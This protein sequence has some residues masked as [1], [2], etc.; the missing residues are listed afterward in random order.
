MDF[1]RGKGAQAGSGF[2]TTGERQSLRVGRFLMAAGTSVLVCVALVVCAF[3]GLLPWPAAIQGS[4]S[5]VALFAGFY[6]LFRTGLNLRFAD[7]SLITEQVGAVLL[8][9]AV[10]MYH[11]GPAHTPLVAFYFVALLFGVLRLNARR[12]LALAVLALAAHATML[13]LQY[14]RNPGMDARAALTEF[15]VLAIVLPW[16]AVM[17]GY[18]NGLR[19]RLSESHRNLQRAYGRIEELAI[20]DE[21]TGAYN[22][23]FLMDCLA[24]ERS[25]AE[26]QSTPYSVCLIDIDR[27]KSFNDRFGHAAG[28]AVLKHFAALVPQELR[29]IDLYG[30]FGGEEFLVVLP[31]TGSE[32]AL[33]CAERVRARTAATAFPGLPGEEK[34]TITV[35][36]ATH[37]RGEEA[38]TLLGRADAALYRGKAE[39]RNRV[40]AA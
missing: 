28:D 25:R 2:E 5:I 38:G 3:L 4:A 1:F 15:V 14:L 29:S 39:G 35:G 18:V 7:P 40:V 31:D 6:V 34:V 17:G 23:R 9:L 21:L 19:A 37:E 10:I 12:M 26:R 30:R 27:F 8:L 32:G 20:R 36:V 13:H 22:R 24:R 16:F 11:T 33:A